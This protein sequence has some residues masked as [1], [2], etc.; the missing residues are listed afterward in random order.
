M[1]SRKVTIDL[2]KWLWKKY[3]AYRDLPESERRIAEKESHIEETKNQRAER[4]G[5]CKNRNEKKGHQ[6]KGECIGEV[7][8][9]K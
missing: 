1:L 2:I 6:V 3:H 4:S 9:M 8:C 7:E 5:I